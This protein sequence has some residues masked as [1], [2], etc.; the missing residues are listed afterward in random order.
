MGRSPLSDRAADRLAA[1]AAQAATA[2]TVLVQLIDGTGLRLA[3]G[4]G[5][6]SAWQVMPDVPLTSTLA[7]LVLSSGFPVVVADVQRDARVPLD[8]PLR[9]VGGRA[10]L[11]FP[12]R[13]PGENAVGICSAIDYRPRVWTAD[14]MRALDHAAQAC[15]ALVAK[16]L[17]RQEVDRQRGFLDAVLDSLNVG[18]IACDAEGRVTRLNAAVRALSGDPP[19]DGRVDTWARELILYDA[20]GQPLPPEDVPLLRALRGERVRDVELV[21]IGPD[22]RRRAF[23][24]DGQAIPGTGGEIAGAVMTLHEVTAQRRVE[25]FRAAELAVT[26]ALAEADTVQE[27]GPRVLAAVAASLSWPHA[28]LWLVDEGADVLRPVARWTAPEVDADLPVPEQLSR[29]VGLAGAAWRDGQILWIRDVETTPSGLSADVARRCRLRAAL[30]FPVR[31]G[32]R[33]LGVLAVFA[34]VVEDPEDAVVALLSG[35]AA[36]IGQYLERR[37]AEELERQLVRSKDDYLA[38]VGHELRTPLTSIAAGV[39]L[40]RDLPDGVR[41][42]QWPQLLEMVDRN[43]VALRRVVD[44]LL[45]LAALDAGH[46]TIRYQPL[47]LAELVRE[48]VDDIEPATEAAGLDLV[49]DLPTEL[50]IAGDRRRLRQVVDNLLDN[51]VK[52][53]GTG[54]RISV[55]L[56]RDGD[57]AQLSIR[58]TGIGIPAPD[59]EQVF[60]HLYR[61]PYARDQRIPGSG[62]GLVM[63]R[64][65][66]ERH[67]GRIFLDGG[68]GPGTCVVMRVPGPSGGQLAGIS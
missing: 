68:D 7:G 44:D 37:R 63:C 38:L 29:G 21:L 53:T 52:F 24:V 10:Y 9:A 60:L 28:E 16:Q 50:V 4:V 11:G 51:A 17:A 19:A 56:R 43:T 62:L 23:S 39:E 54:G 42:A 26:S 55:S 33:V 25:R 48:A 8:A 41:A 32:G 14:E 15:A 45:D 3:G 46:A 6:P 59:R 1:L 66:V 67:G 36:H 61:S 40:L 22:R 34:D 2:P 13:D 64:A 47:D 65:I 20:D 58:D 27:A 31:S 35:I 49:A 12:I 30:A 18:V 57:W 5:L